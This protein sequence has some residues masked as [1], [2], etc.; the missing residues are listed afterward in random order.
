MSDCLLSVSTDFLIIKA[1]KSDLEKGAY[2]KK[3]AANTAVLFISTIAV[4]E[5]EPGLLTTPKHKDL[6]YAISNILLY[7]LQEML[8]ILSK[9]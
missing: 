4:F 8:V 5:S 1:G 2:D 7:I 9:Y 3:R 6:G